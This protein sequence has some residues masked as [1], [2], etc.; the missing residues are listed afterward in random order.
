MVYLKLVEGVGDT[1]GIARTAREQG[2]KAVADPRVKTS[3]RK[4][5]VTAELVFAEAAMRR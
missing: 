4:K 1:A 2:L 3:L 5:T